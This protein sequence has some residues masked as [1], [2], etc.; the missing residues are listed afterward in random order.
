M[1]AKV[2]PGS[3]AV[4]VDASGSSGGLAIIWDA[5]T[6]ELNNIHANKHFLQATFHITGTSIHGHI[7]NVYFP[8]EA[9]HKVKLL[10]TLSS[11]NIDR[12]HLL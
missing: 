9:M 6:I 2:L 3:I 10:N 4:A 11:I 7:T 5:R 1:T 8:Q 12:T